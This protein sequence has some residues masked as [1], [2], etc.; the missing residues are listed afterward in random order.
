MSKKKEL[1]ISNETLRY[2]YQDRLMSGREISSHIQEVYGECLNHQTILRR[3]RDLGINRNRSAAYII[4]FKKHP[5]LRAKFLASGK[6]WRNSDVNIQRIAAI[7]TEKLAKFNASEKGKLHIRKIQKAYQPIRNANSSRTGLICTFCGKE[8]VRMSSKLRQTLRSKGYGDWQHGEEL[9]EGFNAYCAND[10]R[11]KHW[12]V[13]M[14]IKASFRKAFRQTCLLDGTKK[15]MI[16]W[17]EY[18]ERKP[19][20]LDRNLDRQ[21]LAKL[22]PDCRKETA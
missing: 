1:P 10:C 13:R 20:N 2:L 12:G 3:L 4:R 9:P 21:L 8:F 14:G 11:M 18:Q 22:T 17:G 16:K 19:T 6:K 5:E 7:G 15:P